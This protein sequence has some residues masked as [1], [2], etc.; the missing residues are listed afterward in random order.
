MNKLKKMG[1]FSEC[2]KSKS[3][4]SF[5]GPSYAQDLDIDYGTHNYNSFKFH[6]ISII[7]RNNPFAS[8]PTLSSSLRFSFLLF[9]F[10]LVNINSVIVRKQIKIKITYRSLSENP[11]F[12]QFWLC[13]SKD[14]KFC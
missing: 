12:A 11:N 2:E 6:F 9:F 4:I 14:L 7:P 10:F 1:Q 3:R 8:I 5:C 13:N